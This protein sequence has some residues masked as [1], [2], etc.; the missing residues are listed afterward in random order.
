MT[1]DLLYLGAAEQAELIR[2]RRISPVE[3]VRACLDQ[4]E[5]VDDVLRAWITLKPELALKEARRAEDEIGRG[6]Y[7]GPLHGLPY[8]VKDQL[9][10]LGFPTTLGA[11]VLEPTEMEPPYTATAVERLGAAGAILI[12]KQNLHAFGKGGATDFP[13]GQPRNP[14]NPAYS[15][16]SSSSGS[17]IA[18]AAGM[19][20]FALGEDTGGSIRGPASF[21]GVVGIRP[22]YGRVSRFGGVM[23]AY[24]TDTVGPLARRV[25]DVALVLQVVAGH[26]PRDPLSGTEPVPD[27]AAQL[28]GG[29]RG[30]RL[31]IIREIVEPDFVHP[32][33]KAAFQTAVETLRSLGAVIEDVSLP[34]ARFSVA[35]QRLTADAEV[36][37]WLLSKYLRDRYNRFDPAVRTRLAAG[38]LIPATIY[39]R[40]MCARVIVRRQILDALRVRDA[41][42]CPTHIAPPNRIPLSRD[43]IAPK[44]EMSRLR[45]RQIG[46]HPFSLANVPALSV[47]SGFS[48]DGLPLAL[49]IAGRPYGEATVLRIAHAYERATEWHNR[50]PDLERAVAGHRKE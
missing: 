44:E 12:G 39:N 5:R 24:T 31:G 14:W 42:I 19:C 25:E 18:P 27:Y 13:Y 3:L 16:S 29:V 9:H 17:G 50:R 43:R 41:L 2:T 10:A 1:T 22:T 21:N 30:M 7:R 46:V 6:L 47:P 20:S 8:G 38:C 37:A 4:I 32:K 40:A 36:A 48:G 26:D 49:Q 15:P 23:A 34:Y 33:V 28:D 35:L 45:E 11:R